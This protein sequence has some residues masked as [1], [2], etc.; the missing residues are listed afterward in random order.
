[1]PKAVDVALEYLAVHFDE[2][3]TQRSDLSV[4][5]VS[6]G[7]GVVRFNHVASLV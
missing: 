7:V 1:M 4:L 3:C 2:V 6:T 5:F